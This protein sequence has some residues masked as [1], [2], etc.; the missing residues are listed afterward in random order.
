VGN[1][2]GEVRTGV[3]FDKREESVRYSYDA[4]NR[5]TLTTIDG[6]SSVCAYDD[7]GNLLSDGAYTYVY[8]DFNHLTSRTGAAGTTAYLYDAAGNL[9]R[10]TSPDGVTEYS[11]NAQSRLLKGE[12]D[13]GQSSEYTYN[14]LG[15]RI[16]NV[17]V[18]ENAN[19]GYAN[20]DLDNGSAHIRDYTDA[21]SDGR[22]NWQ[23]TWETEAGTV[24][25]NDFETVT[26]H[27]TVDYLSSANRDIMAVE[28]GSYTQ[29]NVY[30]L[31]GTRISAAFDYTEGTARG[32]VNADG[33][34]GENPASDFAAKLEKVW[35]RVS[36]LSSTLYAV[37]A[38]GEVV[39]HMVYDAWGQP[40]SETYTDANFSGITN[41][42]N[43]TGYT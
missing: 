39:T 9:I 5:L 32:A 22:A 16:K 31:N 2:K 21:L 19:T 6:K 3:D 30:D 38:D 25:Q 23:R 1:L 37:D 10:Q 35:F 17:Q 20:A 42:N 12:K 7:A 15:A 13:D 41:L 34:Y 18:R 43:F 29:R 14:A 8:D 4:G 11:Y 24:Q 27:Y 26:T 28:E 36:H 33:D 40:F